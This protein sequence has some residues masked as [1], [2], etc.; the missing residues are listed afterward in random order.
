MLN[1]FIHYMRYNISMSKLLTLDKLNYQ[2]KQVFLRV[3]YNVVEDGKIID[4]FRIEQSL[5]TINKLLQAKC[6]IILASHNGRPDGRPDPKLS[7]RPVAQALADLLKKPVGFV[8]DCIGKE[9]AEEAHNLKP[10][11]IL[12]LE[13]L[14]FHNAEEK[15]NAAFAR[16]LANLAEIYVDDAFA[17]A[18]R[19]HASMVGVPKYLPHAAG[20]LMEQEYSKLSALL[21]IPARPFVAII[22][23]AKISTKIEVLQSLIKKVDTLVIGGAMANTFLQAM[24]H[25]IGKSKTEEDYI[26][27]AKE[28]IEMAKK[29][30]VK[31]VLPI[32]VVVSDKPE[33]GVKHCTV[34]V[35]KI[36]KTEMALDIGKETMK[37]IW[38]DIKLA[39]TIFW[40]GTLG[41]AEIEEY[42]WASR[43]LAHMMAL[44]KNKAETVIGG[45]DTTAFV[46]QLGMHNRFS[47]VSTGG[48]ASL[49]LLAGKK[50]PAIEALMG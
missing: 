2:A 30:K 24:G 33:Q 11:E 46:E 32:D 23:G 47:F 42:A 21:T 50:L 8:P 16:G 10:G 39:K 15:N 25:E 45:G 28:I 1:I 43:D 36:T 6:S 12:L 7:L 29:N 27:T 34:G 26:D 3:D 22:G 40:N 49:E 17:N 31:L 41:I 19:A 4:E 48:G 5:P 9:V 14:R 44:R 18:H 20:I 37:M 35:N 38:P 13:N